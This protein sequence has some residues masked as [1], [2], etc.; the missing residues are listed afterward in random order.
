[1]NPVGIGILSVLGAFAGYVYIKYKMA[2]M[3][4][5]ES[6]SSGFIY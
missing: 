6:K 3:L 5:N 1:M 2:E 4:H